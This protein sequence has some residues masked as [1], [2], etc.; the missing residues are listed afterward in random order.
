M[1]NETKQMQSD[2]ALDWGFIHEVRQTI[3]DAGMFDIREA[4]GQYKSGRQKYSGIFLSQDKTR[5]VAKRDA[6]QLTSKGGTNYF[7]CRRHENWKQA[8]AERAVNAIL[9]QDPMRHESA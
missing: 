1:N 4:D 6:M 5:I 2:F 9:G 7:V 3:P 8:E